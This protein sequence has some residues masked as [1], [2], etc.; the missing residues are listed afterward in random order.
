MSTE[1]IRPIPDHLILETEEPDNPPLQF[2]L[3]LNVDKHPESP[4]IPA[5]ILNEFVYCP[6]L[7]YLEWVQKEWEDSSD[8]VEGRHVHRRVDRKPEPLPDP[9]DEA[10]LKDIKPARSVELSSSKLDLVAKIDLIETTP[11]EKSFRWSTSAANGL[12]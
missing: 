6:R 7:A 11:V 4:L 3:P 2:S 8:T 5:R 9:E 1:M 12:T 10:E